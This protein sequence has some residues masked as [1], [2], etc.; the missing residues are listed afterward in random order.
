MFDIIIERLEKIKLLFSFTNSYEEERYKNSV[1]EATYHTILDQIH[2]TSHSDKDLISLLNFY[3]YFK[4]NLPISSSIAFLDSLQRKN[5]YITT[6]PPYKEFLNGPFS[7][8]NIIY[9]K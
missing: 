5:L 7:F 6:I 1:E 3:T 2:F 8:K 4:N 9:S